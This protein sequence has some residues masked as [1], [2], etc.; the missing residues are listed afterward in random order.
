MEFFDDPV[1]PDQT[2]SELE[3]GMGLDDEIH[4]E[5]IEEIHRRVDAY[6]RGESIPLE[7]N[8]AIENL[9]RTLAT[10]RTS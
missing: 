6:D 9:R 7:F 3:S 4:A 1:N 5:W 10:R 2:I 8:E